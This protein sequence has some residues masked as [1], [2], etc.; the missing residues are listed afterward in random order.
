MPRKK[1]SS[2][3]FSQYFEEWVE[4]YKVGAVHDVT[5]EKYYMTQQ[6]IRELVPDL[7]ISELDRTTYQKLL[8]DYALTH[9]KQ[10][11]MDFHHQLKGA[12]LDAVDDGILTKNPTRKIIIKGKKQK[13]KK[14]KFLNQ[15]E[16]QS[17]MQQLELENEINWDW[18]ILLI[19]KTGLRFSEALALTPNDFDFHNQ[20]IIVNKTWNYKKAS[21]GFQA[22]K[23]ES[24]KRKVSIDWQL[25]MQFS[26]LIKNSEY[27]KPIFVNGRVFNSTIN[28]RLEK[29]C[30]QANVPVITVHSLRHT[31]ASL[32]IF[33]GVSIASIANRLGHS[34]MTTTQETYLHIIQEL[35]NQDNDKIMRHLAML[36]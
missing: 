19:T 10:T 11:T 4:L 30:L 6:R 3:L 12:I 23:N 13:E 17:L 29:L 24:S 28:N 15:F 25:A 22:T 36:M 26:Q 2:Q 32:L 34:S 16:V 33:A 27:D 20:K 31:H 18:F 7:K 9:E 8:N 21:G 35:E 14:P 5:L 1:K